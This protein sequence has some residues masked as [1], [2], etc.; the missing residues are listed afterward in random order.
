[1]PM[2]EFRFAE[3]VACRKKRE[4]QVAC[5]PFPLPTPFSSVET[6]ALTLRE[7]GAKTYDLIRLETWLHW[8]RAVFDMFFNFSVS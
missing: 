1:M 7:T 5:S 3:H 4:T 6:I 2:R 8:F